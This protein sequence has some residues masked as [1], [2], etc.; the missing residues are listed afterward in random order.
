M[1]L[2]IVGWPLC[3]LLADWRNQRRQLGAAMEAAQ[4]Y[5]AG[6]I[7]MGKHDE[8]HDQAVTVAEL[9]ERAAEEG[10]PLRLNWSTADTDPYGLV[11]PPDTDD[12]PT[13]VLPRVEDTMPDAQ[14][15]APEA[16]TG[17][18]LPKRVPRNIPEPFCPAYGSEDT[19]MMERILRGLRGL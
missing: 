14:T 5:V 12:W 17:S 13:G 10:E 15:T 16:D 2:G 1:V 19:A 7:E 8:D 11:A 9:L 3:W 4:R 6:R 18:D